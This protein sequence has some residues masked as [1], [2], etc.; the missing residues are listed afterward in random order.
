ME[1]CLKLYIVLNYDSL[2]AGEF[3]DVFV[4]KDKAEALRHAED[5]KPEV[6]FSCVHERSVLVSDVLKHIGESG[7]DGTGEEREIEK[8]IE[9]AALRSKKIHR[10]DPARRVQKNANVS[11]RKG[12]S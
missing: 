11:S 1:K 8:G 4:D 6:S 2:N 7:S 9:K 3:V 10:K 5:E 12:K